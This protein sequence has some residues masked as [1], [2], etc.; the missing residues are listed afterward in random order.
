MVGFEGLEPDWDWIRQIRPAGVIL[1]T[2]NIESL[3]QLQMLVK[4]LRTVDPEPFI[5][6]DME[7]G[8]VNRL[9]H[10]LGDF[11]SLARVADAG[12]TQ[13]AGRVMG[14]MLASL[15]INV[16]FAPVADLDYGHVNN[17]LHGRTLGAD[18]I[19]VIRET[20]AFVTGLNELGVSGCF[21][22]FPGLGTTVPDS[23][24]SLPVY[25]ADEES[26]QNEEGAVYRNLVELGM[27]DVPVMLAHCRIPFWEDEVASLSHWATSS[28][29]F[30]NWTGITMTDDLEMKAIDPSTVGE[31][32][33]Q[34][35]RSG[36]DLVMVCRRR[37]VVD[38]VVSSMI[39]SGFDACRGQS[40]PYAQIGQ[41]SLRQAKKEWANFCRPFRALV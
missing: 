38:D 7:G 20:A 13:E 15:G 27:G 1:F 33:V 8:R 23:H 11:P 25:G 41:V 35:L 3:D 32:A 26:W 22:H 16:D 12:V 5:A 19:K 9:Q 4:R 37:A 29:R 6:M 2:R 21:K 24:F 34:A 18:P 39:E 36:V 40:L 28:L 30:M 31:S 10:L 17:G 14:T